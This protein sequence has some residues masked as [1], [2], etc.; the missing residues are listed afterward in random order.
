MRIKSEI[1]KKNN[2]VWNKKNQLLKLIQIKKNTIK[3][4]RTK[5]FGEKT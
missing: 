2:G 5:S 3:R 4:A 1:I